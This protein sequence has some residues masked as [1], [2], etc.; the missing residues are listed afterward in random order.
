MRRRAVMVAFVVLAFLPFAGSSQQIPRPWGNDPGNWT[1]Y[2]VEP[3]DLAQALNV[4]ESRGET[5]AFIVQAKT[6][7][8]R[9]CSEYG[10]HLDP[11][12][13]QTLCVDPPPEGCPTTGVSNSLLFVVVCRKS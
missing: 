10:C 1:V 7:E 9:D 2:Y 12:S 11:T 13:G 6:G 3:A 4:L 5:P 8:E